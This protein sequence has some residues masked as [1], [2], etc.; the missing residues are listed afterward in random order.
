MRFREPSISASLRYRT[1]GRASLRSS[2]LRAESLQIWSAARKFDFKRQ[3]RQLQLC[4]KVVVP[5][6]T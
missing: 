2:A 5:R 6:D 3:K 1:F 4:S